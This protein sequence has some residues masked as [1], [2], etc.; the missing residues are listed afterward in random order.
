LL[1]HVAGT[2]PDFHPCQRIVYAGLTLT[3]RDILMVEQRQLDILGYVQLVDQIEA[4]ENKS[5]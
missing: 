5:Y 4:L 1:R 3:T 2:M